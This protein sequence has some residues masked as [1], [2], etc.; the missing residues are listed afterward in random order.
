MAAPVPD[1]TLPQAKWTRLPLRTRPH[2]NPLAENDDGHPT[3]P[4]EVAAQRLPRYYPAHAADIAAGKRVEIADIGCAFGGMLVALAPL[5][6]S[7]LMVGLEIRTKVVGFAQQRIVELRKNADTA[8]GHHDYNNV[9]FEQCNVMKFGSRFFAKGQLQKL[10]FAHPD[11]HWKAKNVRRRIISPGLVQTYAYWLAEGG[12]LY[13]VSDVPELE[14]W[15]VECLDASPL[16]QRLTDDE[17]A[18]DKA[19]LDITKGTSEDAQRAKRKGLPPN[20]A[21]HRR[22]TPPAGAKGPVEL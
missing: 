9:W 17:L 5:F 1:V 3:C 14:Q 8:Q 10:F 11:P 13:T 22:V 12:L 19:V 2:R 4:D 15:M 7:T 21:V 18:A 20:F 6:P 16:F